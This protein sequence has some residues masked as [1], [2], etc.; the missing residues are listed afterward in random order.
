MT[1]YKNVLNWFTAVLFLEIVLVAG[2]IAVACMVPQ[3][4]H[5]DP[6]VG[7]QAVRLE[8]RSAS[9]MPKCILPRTVRLGGVTVKGRP[10]GT[11]QRKVLLWIINEGHRRH[12]P[13][14]VIIAAIAATT[15]ESGARELHHGTGTSLGPWQLISSHGTPAQRISVEFSGTWFFDG[16]MKVYRGQ[17][18]ITAA[19]LAQ[20][21]ERSA[22][23]SAYRA[24]V[25][26]ARR[27][28]A[29]INGPCRYR[30]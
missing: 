7:A 3:E 12:L 6:S 18:S 27:T 2:A 26:E 28:I 8:P 19:A 20:A 17:R 4:A 10:I 11:N 16:A 23:P 14:V 15:Q 29:R 13:R 22:Y 9:T 5:G 1:N 21:V 24:W 30:S 25:P